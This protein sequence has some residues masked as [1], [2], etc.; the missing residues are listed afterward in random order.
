MISDV[1]F[2]SIRITPTNP[3][4]TEFNETYSLDN[5]S[6]GTPTTL[7]PSP[8]AVGRF[9]T[10]R[11]PGSVS[12]SPRRLNDLGQVVGS[13]DDALGV[14]RGFIFDLNT[15]A[16][17]IVEVV[18]AL[19]TITHS[20]NNSG[21][22]VGNY[23]DLATGVA[24]S[25][26]L[27]NGVFTFFDPP[28]VGESGTNDISENGDLAGNLRFDA[29]DPGYRLRLCARRR[30]RRQPHPPRVSGRDGGDGPQRRQRR[31]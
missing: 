15:G 3:T 17:T 13:V 7:P 2:N 29:G 28:G 1:G 4:D 22:A 12:T 6:F 31:T 5:L 19:L 18:G 9:L 23:F 27:E 10:F 25:Y 16:S 24:H 14:R 30:H 21:V 26:L 8:S 20:I 11:V